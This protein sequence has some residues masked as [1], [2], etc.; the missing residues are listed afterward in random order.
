MGGFWRGGM[1][2]GENRMWKGY[3]VVVVLEKGCGKGQ[4]LVQWERRTWGA[5]DVVVVER[6]TWEASDVVAVVVERRTC[7]LPTPGYCVLF[8]HLASVF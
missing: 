2:R 7:S 8:P 3:V 5:S 1:C 4:M 6:R